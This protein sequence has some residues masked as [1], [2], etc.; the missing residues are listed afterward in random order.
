MSDIL[1]EA[2]S[3]A[4][5]T[6][7][8]SE[9]HSTALVKDIAAIGVKARATEKLDDV[10]VI[11][12]M[13]GREVRGAE[14]IDKIAPIIESSGYRF[15]QAKNIDTEQPI[16]VNKNAISLID[17][18]NINL[19]HFEAQGLKGQTFQFVKDADFQ[20]FR[21]SAGLKMSFE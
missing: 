10:V 4:I 21:Q 5:R 11:H 14:S 13:S 19:A 6:G 9:E 15:Y 20:D 12:E 7:F 3:I 1:K 2:A 8:N 16:L 18:D 17:A